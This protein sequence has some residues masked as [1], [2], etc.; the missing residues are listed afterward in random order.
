[1]RRIA[2][3]GLA[4][5]SIVVITQLS[6]AQWHA[7]GTVLLALTL[8]HGLTALPWL[9]ASLFAWRYWWWKRHALL[10]EQMAADGIDTARRLRAEQ[11]ERDRAELATPA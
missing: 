4:A 11:W 2:L 6:A 8:A 5:T 9:L 3:L 7:A 1:M 10:N